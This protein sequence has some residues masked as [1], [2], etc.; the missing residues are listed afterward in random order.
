M[1]SM[2]FLLVT[3]FLA[4]IIHEFIERMEKLIRLKIQLT[5][6]PARLKLTH[7]S[8]FLPQT[9]FRITS[10]FYENQYPEKKAK[11]WYDHEIIF[12]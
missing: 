5:N 7:S 12:K 4:P 11:F 10:L 9:Q 8:F 1:Q 3:M 2:K 6:F